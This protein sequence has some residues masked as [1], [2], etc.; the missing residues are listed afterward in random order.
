[1]SR[2][3]LVRIDDYEIEAHYV[4]FVEAELRRYT[5]RKRRLGNLEDDIIRSTSPED[6]TGMPRPSGVGNPTA[7]KA[8]A[9]MKNGERSHLSMW[10]RLVDDVYKAL[11]I[12]QRAAI[13]ILYFEN[14]LTMEGAAMHLHI[15]RTTLWRHRNRALL[16]YATEMI[17]D[18]VV[19]VAT[20]RQQ[21]RR[22]NPS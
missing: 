3:R 18:H 11:P 20:N 9:L 6:N 7:S 5:S 12:E 21:S 4:S 2:R 8:L 15:D 10:C 13:R 14:Q 22:V 16:A 17:G 19:Q 1:V